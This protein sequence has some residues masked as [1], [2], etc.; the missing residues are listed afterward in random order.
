M[1]RQFKKKLGRKVGTSETFFRFNL[2]T[3]QT[4]LI[5]EPPS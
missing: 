2:L 4:M 1:M 5:W 3:I